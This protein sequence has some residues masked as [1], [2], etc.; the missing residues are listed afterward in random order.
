MI[1]ADIDRDRSE[2]P[3]FALQLIFCGVFVTVDKAAGQLLYDFPHRRFREVLASKHIATAERYL[4]LVSRLEEGQFAEFL[5]VFQASVWFKDLSFQLAAAQRIFSQAISQPMARN[6]KLITERFIALKPSAF[7]PDE[8]AQRFVS[9]ALGLSHPKFQV[10]R[11][12]LDYVTCDEK[13]LSSIR[14][15]LE[16]GKAS[17]DPERIQL[18]TEIM[19]CFNKPLLTEWLRHEPSWMLKPVT[20]AF[21]QAAC[22]VDAELIVPHASSLNCNDLSYCFGYY[23][24]GYWSRLRERPDPIGE[25]FCHLERKPRLAA[26]F[27]IAMFFPTVYDEIRALVRFDVASDLFNIL[28]DY[29]GNCIAP[30]IDNDL[31]FVFSS[32]NVEKAAA[33]VAERTFPAAL[34]RDLEMGDSGDDTY[35]AALVGCELQEEL[36]RAL[37]GLSGKIFDGR[38]PIEAAVN[39]IAETIISAAEFVAASSFWARKGRRLSIEEMESV[40]EFRDRMMGIAEKICDITETSS[41]L[42]KELHAELVAYSFPPMRSEFF[43]A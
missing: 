40:E 10:T 25:I 20:P 32:T 27:A 26:F 42:M 33:F 11:S 2:R 28:S 18:C 16:T 1:L 29:S 5:Q 6:W 12:L 43:F 17:R 30:P 24:A 14:A 37:L 35:S 4:E 13:L 39:D 15:S 34:K 38:G 3:N 41:A 9:D 23:V 22:L 36:R 8:E 7:R 21:I 19:L 31:C